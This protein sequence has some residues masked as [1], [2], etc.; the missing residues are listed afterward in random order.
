M[1]QTTHMCQSVAGAI[2]NW[3]RR[4][5]ATVAA[6]NGTTA[7]RLKE[8]FRI[9]EF[10]GVKVIPFGKPCEGFSDQTGCPGHPINEEADANLSV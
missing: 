5:W 8:K 3:T 2:A 1:R 6:E 9:M 4:D 10:E 7:D